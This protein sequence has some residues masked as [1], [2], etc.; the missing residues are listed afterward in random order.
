MKPVIGI[1]LRY[2]K[3]DD[4]R[5]IAYLSER[6]RRTIQ[7]AGGFVYPICPVQNVDYIYT[8]G[9][10]FPELTL[11]EKM[12]I[13]RSI[14]SCDGVIFPGG[15][16]FTP[17]DRYVLDVVIE[18]K[19]PVLGICLGMQLMSCY[20]E[21]VKLNDIKTE[22]NHCQDSDLELT[23]LVRINKDSKL[24]EII[25]KEQ[26]LVNSFHKRCANKNSIYKVTAI[27]EDGL[28]E[29][30]EYPSAVFNIGV[31]WHP[32][33]SYEFDSNS[34]KIIDAFITSAKEKSESKEKSSNILK[35]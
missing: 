28:I 7:L 2:Q 33:I 9:N 6:L 21:E 11:E 20:Q 15:M 1:L 14:D 10:E 18:K 22:I 12:D 3:L 24:Y 35:C 16:K 23:H 5:A 26:I 27:S 25:G 17:Y 30:I 19:I 34:R 4:D 13:E 29:G 8:K 32:E 31:Q